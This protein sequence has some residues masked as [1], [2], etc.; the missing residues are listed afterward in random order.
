MRRSM[1]AVTFLIGVILASGI[2]MAAAA[3][4]TTTVKA[5]VDKRGALRLRGAKR[6]RPGTRKITLVLT[7]A[8]GSP[9]ASGAAGGTGPAGPTGP[10]GRTGPTGPAGTPDPS[11]FYTKGQADARFAKRGAEINIPGVAFQ[12]ID[13]D[14]GVNYADFFGIYEQGPRNY[15]AA[16]LDAL[17]NG[18]TITSVDFFVKHVSGGQTELA[19]SRSFA[20][21]GAATGTHSA[22]VTL[23]YTTLSP[24]VAKVTLTPPGGG[25]TPLPGVVAEVYWNP[26]NQSADDIL[27]MVTVHYTAP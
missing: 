21:P 18:A 5:C 6:C 2:V 23:P 7:G 10:A 17:P 1:P 27:Y 8:K 13:S 16:P 3:S 14:T 15:A 12:P 9:G 4:K 26:A 25:Y 11:S 22:V 20:T 19:L 24:D